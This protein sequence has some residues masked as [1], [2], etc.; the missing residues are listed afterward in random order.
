V[1]IICVMANQ[2]QRKR[3]EKEMRHGI[4]IVE[5]DEEGNERV[6]ESSEL[7][8]AAPPPRVKGSGSSKSRASEPPRRGVPQP[9]SWKRAGKRT[10]IFAPIFFIFVLLT[11]RERNVVGALLT[12]VPLILLFVPMSYYM[13]RFAYRMYQKRIA[14]GAGAGRSR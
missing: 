5:I 7:K 13:D 12:M 6:L 14:K 2:K 8:P 9:P 1:G 4:E 10:A 3:R 11:S